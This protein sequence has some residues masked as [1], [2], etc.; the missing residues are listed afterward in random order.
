M[1]YLRSVVWRLRLGGLLVLTALMWPLDAFAEDAG[2]AVSPVWQDA[3]TGQIEAFRHGDGE[4]AL[5]FAGF[6]F[7]V[8]YRDRDPAAF[9]RDIK[10][11]GYGPI[12]DSSSHSFGK[13]QIRDDN[14][15]LQVVKIFGPNQGLYQALYQLKVEGDG[16][17][18]QSVILRKEPGIGV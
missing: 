10:R 16:W 2:A 6:A 8:R 7:Q 5:S 17:R 1:T 11:S 18:V 4:K 12:M 14:A 3:I 13:F 15:V 9:V